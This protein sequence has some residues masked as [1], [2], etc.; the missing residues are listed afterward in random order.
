MTDSTYPLFINFMRVI[1]KA[2]NVI[3]V[4]LII[5][6][7][8]SRIILLNCIRKVAG[9]NLSRDIGYCD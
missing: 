9:S 2:C 5:D 6:E 4:F 7:V 1:Q 8:D 3:T